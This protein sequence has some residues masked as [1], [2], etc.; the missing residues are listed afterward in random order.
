LVLENNAG[1]DLAISANG[2][3]AFS[4]AS[5]TGSTYVVTVKT[6]P[7]TSALAQTCTVSSGSGTVASNS[8]TSVGIVCATTAIN[9]K[10]LP[11]DPGTAGMATLAGIDS[12]NDGLRDDIERYVMLN[13]SN[14]AKT[15]AW[16]TQSALAAQFGVTGGGLSSADAQAA[17]SKLDA[18]LACGWYEYGANEKA[19]SDALLMQVLNTKDRVKA[20]AQFTSQLAGQVTNIT[21]DPAQ[22]KAACAIDPTTLPN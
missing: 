15:R 21:T 4:T 20:Y 16:L 13:Y 1:N 19:Q 22:R 8:V 18:A 7:T 5:A 11:P 14:S 10:S 3:F 12:D 17:F 2:P 6:Q 9:G